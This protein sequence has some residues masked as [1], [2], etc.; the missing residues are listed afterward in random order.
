[1]K[2][3]LERSVASV[4]L[5]MTLFASPIHAAGFL[6]K[7]DKAMKDYATNIQATGDHAIE[8]IKAVADA[9]AHGKL[10]GTLEAVDK[11]MKAYEADITKT[12][13][14]AL[15]SI[16]EIAKALTEF[17]TY[18]PGSIAASI[19]TLKARFLA[20][21]A[22][23]WAE[24]GGG[25]GG[26]AASADIPAP[27][28]AEAPSH[29][30]D[31]PAA[32]HGEHGGGHEEH[33]GGHGAGSMDPAP[34][35]ES[36]TRASGI[37]APAAPSGG[38]RTRSAARLKALFDSYVQMPEL[39]KKIS[40]S[41][42]ASQVRTKY[43]N[44]ATQDLRKAKASLED[45]HPKFTE[46]LLEMLSRDV[47]ALKL[48]LEYTSKLDTS[49]AKMALPTLVQGLVRKLSYKAVSGSN[50]EKALLRRLQQLKAKI[51]R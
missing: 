31:T 15:A 24:D 38:T 2:I 16:K 19:E 8:T 18:L 28:P 26:G 20:R 3:R 42:L 5:G 34:P 12:G 49:R 47:E 27:P 45:S 1:M 33:G 46:R 10:K 22:N 13:D 21:A 35:L 14:D 23:P 40:A 39:A 17:K 44:D 25:G 29:G 4:A 41:R 48:F 37:R 50:S 30:G 11:G 43:R 32:G 36:Q 7:V 51:G 9:L 6:D